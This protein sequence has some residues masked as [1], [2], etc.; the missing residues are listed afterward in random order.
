MKAIKLT[1]TLALLALISSCNSNN[2]ETKA[3]LEKETNDIVN[4]I[5]NTEEQ[6]T[7]NCDDF[8]ITDFNHFLGLSY[9][10]TEDKIEKVLGK[11]TDVKTS[12]NGAQTIYSYKNTLRVP[13]SIS[14]NTDSKKVETLVIEILGLDANFDQDV[15][16]AKEDFNVEPCILDLLGKKPKEILEIL[17]Q[18]NTDKIKESAN[19][20]GVRSLLYLSEDTFTMVSLNFYPSQDNKLS[21]I[22]VNWFYEPIKS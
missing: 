16:K 6:T 21:S 15:L 19:E 3:Q 17:G 18:A 22:T 9:G 20:T 7:V 5:L 4:E 11:P 8:K 14:I 12:S 2:E 1:F 13:V 10:D